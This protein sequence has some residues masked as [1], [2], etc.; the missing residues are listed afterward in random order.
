MKIKMLCVS[1]IFF[2]LFCQ[3]LHA[4]IVKEI[5]PDGALKLESGKRVVLAGIL[6][7]AEGITVFKAVAK[8]RDVRIEDVLNAPQVSPNH[9]YAFLQSKFIRIPYRA[10]DAA[11]AEEVMLN[12]FLI[13]TGAAKVDESQ[14]FPKKQDF[15]KL[16]DEARKKG[17]GIWSY[18]KS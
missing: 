5:D 17:E 4:E 15:L 10:T 1:A 3:E 11:G 16:Q 2:F 8:K 6:M 12:E 13:G 9:V 7:D 14:E 18:E